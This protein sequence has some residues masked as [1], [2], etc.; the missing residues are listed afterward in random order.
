MLHDI[1]QVKGKK[2]RSCNLVL[3]IIPLVV[4]LRLRR[5]AACYLKRMSKT[6]TKLP[7]EVRRARQHLRR[8]GWTQTAAAARFGVTREH[9]SLVLNGHRESRRLLDAVLAL[10]E[11]PDPA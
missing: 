9:L 2:S 11:N 1:P 6:T 5:V 7:P 10:P 3:Q 8:N 4:F